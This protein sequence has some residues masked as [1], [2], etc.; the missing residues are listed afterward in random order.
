MRVSLF[1]RSVSALLL[2]VMLI[3]HAVHVPVACCAIG[4]YA[5]LYH[6]KHVG[7]ASVSV[8]V[9]L[10]AAGECILCEH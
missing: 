9:E 2:M 5:N 1:F 8:R 6:H 10:L 4:Q 7:T 3:L